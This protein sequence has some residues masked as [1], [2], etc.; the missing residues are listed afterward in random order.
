MSFEQA[1]QI[2]GE[3]WTLDM[4]FI[5]ANIAVLSLGPEARILDIG[6][7][8]GM[9]SINLALNGFDVLTGE[10]GGDHQWS[11]QAAHHHDHHG[12]GHGDHGRHEHQDWREV[13]ANLGLTD[14]IDYRHFQAESL[15][16]ASQSFD[17]V[18]MYNTLHHIQD[19][20]RA[21]GECLRVLSPGGAL[22]VFEMNQNGRDYYRQTHGFDHPLLNPMDF[23]AE[24][25][26][27][28]KVIEGP[29]SN[30]YILKKG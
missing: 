14:K 6:T 8:W 18:F 29:Y 15:P 25:G 3:E 24:T 4:D 7:G 26:Q 27:S 21:L 2:W 9:M 11:C 1:K 19:K 10:P 16:F 22:C 28:L 20:M 5:N 17:G 30:A 23:L 12:E 13:A